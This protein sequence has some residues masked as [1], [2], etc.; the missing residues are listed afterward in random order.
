MKRRSFC[1]R[2][3]VCLC[4]VS[5]AGKQCAAFVQRLCRP[6]KNRTEFSWTFSQ[7]LKELV[8]SCTHPTL[9]EQVICFIITLAELKN[10]KNLESSGSGK[11]HGK[12]WVELNVISCRICLFSKLFQSYER[13]WNQKVLL[14]YKELLYSVQEVVYWFK[15]YGQWYQYLIYFSNLLLLVNRRYSFIQQLRYIRYTVCTCI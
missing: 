1:G 9:I 13:Y 7:K 10:S 6:G 8:G 12:W 3:G 5:S 4:A 2:L 14:K 11:N 15:I